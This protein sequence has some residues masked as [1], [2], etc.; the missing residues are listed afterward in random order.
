MVRES[1]GAVPGAGSVRRRIPETG[2]DGVSGSGAF[3]G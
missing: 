3:V 1:S 2:A